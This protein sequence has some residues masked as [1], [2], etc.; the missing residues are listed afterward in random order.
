M[1]WQ[2]S[3]PVLAIPGPAAAAAAL[4][5]RLVA[6]GGA[7]TAGLI[8]GFGLPRAPPETEC[9]DTAHALGCLMPHQVNKL[10][11]GKVKHRPLTD[12]N[13]TSANSN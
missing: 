12:T 3:R 13:T 4:R 9:P 5:R 11:S 7:R 6:G 8:P 1:H 10:P 2:Y